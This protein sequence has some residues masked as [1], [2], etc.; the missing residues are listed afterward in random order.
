MKDL[1]PYH[2]VTQVLQEHFETNDIITVE[3][4]KGHC[5]FERE[6]EYYAMNHLVY[7]APDMPMTSKRV[8]ATSF[9]NYRLWHKINMKLLE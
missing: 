5:D 4:L 7:H 8:A 9:R 6:K 2:L 3:D 1:I